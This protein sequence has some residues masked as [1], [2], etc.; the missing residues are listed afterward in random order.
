MARRK[1]GLTS[2]HPPGQPNR[3]KKEPIM[4]RFHRNLL[5]L[6]M[7]AAVSLGGAT[8]SL[9]QTGTT[10]LRGTILDKSGGAI[11]GATVTLSNAQQGFERVVVSGETGA[12]EFLGLAPGTYL[13]RVEKE[14]FRKYEVSH[15]ELQVNTPKTETITL[16][17]GSS[18]QTV[19]VAAS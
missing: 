8:A 3:C 14:D 13:L 12:Y 1:N 17:V 7:I 9:G 11:A 15:L 2:Q 16:D 19:E 6:F 10:S 5:G 4:V 18:S